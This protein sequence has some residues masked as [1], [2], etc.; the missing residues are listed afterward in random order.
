M[1]DAQAKKT[2]YK[3]CLETMWSSFSLFVIYECAVIAF[4]TLTAKTLGEFADN[5]L[6]LNYTL[7]REDLITLVILILLNIFME[8]LLSIVRIIKHFKQSLRH[9]GQVVRIFL[10]KDYLK[11][12]KI[13]AELTFRWEEDLLNYKEVLLDLI[14]KP[15]IIIFSSVFISWFIFENIVYGIVA[16]LASLLPVV[17]T[18]FTRSLE[19]KYMVQKSDYKSRAVSYESDIASNFV[20]LKTN[21]IQ[22]TYI[23]KIETL[24]N[25]FFIQTAKKDIYLKSKIAFLNKISAYL[26]Q[27][28]I[29]I[30]GV[31]MLSKGEINAGQIASYVI[32]LIPLQKIIE[33]I[34]SFI[35]ARKMYK[36]YSQRIIPF[37]TDSEKT[38]GKILDEQICL[39]EAQD[40]SFGYEPDK[41]VFEKLNFKVLKGE[42]IRISGKNGSGKST[43]VKLLSGLYCNYK[44]ELKVN[45]STY[46]EFNI[47]S[48]RTHIA[49]IEQDPYFFQGTVKENIL[50][51]NNKTDPDEIIELFKQLGFDKSLD[52][53]IE[54]GGSNLSGG[55]KQKLSI[56][57]GLLKKSDLYIF[58]EPTSNL[59]TESSNVLKEIL[60][61]NKNTAIFISH[62]NALDTV[63]CKEIKIGL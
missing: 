36:D 16:I 59:D 37:Y 29:V 41:M 23:S 60:T 57:R 33:N 43:L 19:S 51:V 48:L 32:Y 8:P 34:Q 54:Q 6:K 4:R 10:D 7:I 52:Y 25:D 9:H 38:Y 22:N 50:A 28:V 45:K 17:V 40:L 62:G 30:F 42:K 12:K 56:I 5:I 15:V 26:S 18:Y 11:A 27:V 44:G 3:H 24:F 20:C 21:E 35:K 53:K 1:E 58:D 55:E 63:A 46:K 13:G 39:I 31:Y 2:A 14:T 61:D 47:D 49:Y